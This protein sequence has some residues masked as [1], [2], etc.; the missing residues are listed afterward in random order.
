MG[1]AIGRFQELEGREEVI[2]ALRGFSSEKGAIKGQ[3][4][5]NRQNCAHKLPHDL[6]LC[7]E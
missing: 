5:K 7:I 1:R 6:Y 4:D 3:N 2:V